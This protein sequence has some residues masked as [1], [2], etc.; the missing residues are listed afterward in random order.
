MDQSDVNFGNQPKAEAIW[1][2]DS[3]VTGEQ[4]TN[5]DTQI[6][7]NN[8]FWN[9]SLNYATDNEKSNAHTEFNK[10]QFGHNN[11]FYVKRIFMKQCVTDNNDIKIYP[12]KDNTGYHL[13]ASFIDNTFNSE[14]PLE[15]T[16]FEKLANGYESD[17][18]DCIVTLRRA[19]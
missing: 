3:R 18:Y 13:F 17:C 14:Y 2:D 10:C 12:T 4:W 5:G 11:I 9:V 1:F 7:A 6:I 19:T 16:R 8:C 15:F